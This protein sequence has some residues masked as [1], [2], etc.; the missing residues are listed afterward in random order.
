MEVRIDTWILDKL[1]NE[2]CQSNKHSWRLDNIPRGQ[3]LASSRGFPQLNDVRAAR[4]ER[5][6]ARCSHTRART[7][8]ARACTRACLT[9]PSRVRICS[10]SDYAALLFSLELARDLAVLTLQEYITQFCFFFSLNACDWKPNL[11]RSTP[12]R[13]CLGG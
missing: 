9:S 12:K 2:N 13:T 7:R 8:A 10:Q 1:R 5:A 6:P 11:A 3:S 4:S